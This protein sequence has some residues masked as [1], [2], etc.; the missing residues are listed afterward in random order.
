MGKGERTKNKP[1]NG[2]TITIHKTVKATQMKEKAN[3]E[4]ITS[5]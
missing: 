1:C 3:G 4:G 5:C 2:T